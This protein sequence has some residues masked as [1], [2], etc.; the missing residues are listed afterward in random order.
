[1]IQSLNNQA[2]TTPPPT[3][4]NTKSAKSTTI[5]PPSML[6]PSSG[7]EEIVMKATS[8]WIKGASRS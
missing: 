6:S 7:I 3:K 2:P 5:S 8:S 4:D 1:M